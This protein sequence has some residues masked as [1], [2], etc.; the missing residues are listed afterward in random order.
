MRSVELVDL[1]RAF[2]TVQVLQH[3]DLTVHAG[4]HLAL[5]GPSGSGKSTLLRLIAG[6]DAPDSG[7]IRFDGV[8]QLALSPH[9]RDVAMVFQNYA[10]YPH[11][12]VLANISTGLR[13][14]KK[15]P[16]VEAEQLARKV[17]ASVG[18][19]E[20]L[21]RKPKDLSG[22][23]RQRVALARAIARGSGT[24]LLDEPL[25]GLDAQLRVSVRTEIFSH[26]R[27]TGATVIHVTHDQADA[28][29]G[30]DRI[31][32]I[33]RGRIRQVGTPIEVYRAPDDL[34]VAQFFGVPRMTAF[35]VAPAGPTSGRSPFG[36]HES[37]LLASPVRLGI[38]PEHL[39][40]G[41]E[42]R[43]TA[44]A[45]VIS[46]ELNGPDYVAYVDVEGTITALRH[47]ADPPRPGQNV[48]ISCDPTDVHVFAGED[49]AR[50]GTGILLPL[51]TDALQNAN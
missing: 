32:V 13:F 34:F 30:A 15:L 38:R 10:L 11:L 22:G 46:V 36:V 14:G 4:E 37:S 19:A 26:L 2:G 44:P 23:Q 42:R 3:V 5:L 16:K 21:G 8:S 51:A 29:S 7:D 40:F 25:S 31:A 1:N 43:W 47:A 48:D 24:V 50:Q 28:L 18:I 39:V 41:R 12:N 45:H 49:F 33:D 35:T 6:L 17:A 27:A 20:L 9:E